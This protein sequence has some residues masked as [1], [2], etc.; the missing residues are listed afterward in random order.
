MAIPAT[1][2]RNA[3]VTSR[4]GNFRAYLLHLTFVYYFFSGSRVP[5]SVQSF[6]IEVIFLTEVF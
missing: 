3:N 2:G 4:L 5:L 1:S 6:L